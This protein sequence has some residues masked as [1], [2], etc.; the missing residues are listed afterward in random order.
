MFR[1]KTRAVLGAAT[2]AISILAIGA[3]VGAAPARMH[4]HPHPAGACPQTVSLRVNGPQVTRRGNL[5]QANSHCAYRFHADAGD[6][7]VWSESGAAIRVVITDPA[8]NADGPGV[9][10]SYPLTKTGEY[11]FEVGANLMADG[12]FGPYTLHLRLTH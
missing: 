2:L 3:P 6:T 7:L 1:T 10:N 4:H 12:G 9:P 11:T 5:T 8:G